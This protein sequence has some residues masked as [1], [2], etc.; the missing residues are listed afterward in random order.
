MFFK[1]IFLAAA[2][3]ALLV[4]AV[5]T[6]ADAQGFPYGVVAATSSVGIGT[7]STR[8]STTPGAPSTGAGG[9][10]F[11]NGILLGSSALIVV[12]GSVYLTRKLKARQN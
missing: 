2:F 8:T 6:V 4:V 1:R 11:M 3:V 10:A 5:A 9:E 7:T 12:G